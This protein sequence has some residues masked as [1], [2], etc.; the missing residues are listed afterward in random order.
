MIELKYI[1][2]ILTAA[3][4]AMFGLIS[5]TAMA[6]KPNVIL[7]LADDLGYGDLGYT[8]NPDFPTPNLD[9][10]ANGG[11]KFTM[12][13][14]NHSFCSP[15]R[16]ALITGKYQQRFGYENNVPG[17]PHDMVVGLPVE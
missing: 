15:T 9:R 3:S 8:G 7:I 1:Q 13:Y 12:G 11:V 2:T 16:A 4:L 10:L 6:D 17:A 5:L 14:S